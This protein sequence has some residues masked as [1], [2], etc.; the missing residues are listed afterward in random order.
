MAVKHLILIEIVALKGFECK[1]SILI[2]FQSAVNENQIRHLV[3]LPQA[4]EFMCV[5]REWICY[6]Q[7]NVT[8]HPIEETNIDKLTAW[9][10]RLIYLRTAS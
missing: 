6:G 1:I 8:C 7:K 3:T 5:R 10:V 2:D 4:V 9:N